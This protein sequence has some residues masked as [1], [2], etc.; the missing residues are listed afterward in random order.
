M[1][2]KSAVARIAIV[3][4]AAQ[5]IGRAVALRLAQDGL[6][7]AVNDIPAKADELANVVS[8]I[9]AKGRRAVAVPADVTVEKEVE[10]MVAKA[11]DALGGVDVVSTGH[12][13][14]L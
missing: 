2:S 1:A 11:V 12:E 3:T 4:G 6:D 5:G 13:A 14:I 9:E 7:V 8:L 10:D